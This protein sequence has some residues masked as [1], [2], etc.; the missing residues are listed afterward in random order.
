MLWSHLLHEIVFLNKSV[1][2]SLH[3]SISY[4]YK[5]Q[6]ENSS[7]DICDGFYK[8]RILNYL[9]FILIVTLLVKTNTIIYVKRSHKIIGILKRIRDYVNIDTLKMTH[10]SI[11]LSHIYY[12]CVIW[13]IQ[14]QVNV[15]RICKLQK[16]A[17]RVML[18]CK[19]QNISSNEIFKTMN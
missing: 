18:R 17:A 7:P 12:G 15:N 2:K 10:N 14:N 5:W 6:F 19:I 16:R 1:L 8:N 13:G 11:L 4:S 9:E 3:F